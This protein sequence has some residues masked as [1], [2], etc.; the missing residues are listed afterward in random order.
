MTKPE[1]ISS[2]AVGAPLEATKT[3]KTNSTK[4]NVGDTVSPFGPAAAELTYQM[5]GGTTAAAVMHGAFTGLSAGSSPYYGGMPGLMGSGKYVGGY[6][7][8]GNKYIG[9]TS[10]GV[11][12]SGMSQTEIFNAMN[13]KSQ[14]LL[15]L[16]A[17]LQQN[18]QAWNAK[19]NIISADH[20]AR[21]A[22]IEKFT[23]R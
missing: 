17:G 20:R 16:Q 19:S 3:S 11:A 15:V 12:G 22:M 5:G 7:G 2:K 14:E 13:E 4:F 10:G 6:E 21:M 23:G 18:M 1:H 9:D 8:Y